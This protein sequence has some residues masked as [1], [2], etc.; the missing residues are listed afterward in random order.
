MRN[1]RCDMTLTVPEEAEMKNME[2][3]V[4]MEVSAWRESP[5]PPV[6]R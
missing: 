3:K 6:M 2:I 5:P 1:E 4:S